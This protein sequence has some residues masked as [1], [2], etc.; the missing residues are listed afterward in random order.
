MNHHHPTDDLLLQATRY[1]LEEMDATERDQFEQLLLEDQPAREAVA[2]AV[3]LLVA[4]QAAREAVADR[5]MPR[6]PVSLPSVYSS[7]RLVWWMS[8]AA[9][10]LLVAA[11][12]TIASRRLPPEG[13]IAQVTPTDTDQPEIH[14]ANDQDAGKGLA[15]VWARSLAD[16]PDRANIDRGLWWD[17]EIAADLTEGGAR[18]EG[19]DAAENEDELA[20]AP[21][22]WMLTALAAQQEM[23]RPATDMTEQV[24]ESR[25]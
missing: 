5:P 13:D 2:S 21:P 22:S 14:Q 6:G 11:V 24:E 7:H 20:L 8:A 4:T 9:A 10:C 25:Q 19:D 16:E 17:M 12:L 23:L 18:F 1:V 3:E 15:Q